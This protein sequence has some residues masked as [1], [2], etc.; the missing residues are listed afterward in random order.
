MNTTTTAQK[1]VFLDSFNSEIE[2]HAPKCQDVKRK[3]AQRKAEEAFEGEYASMKD[4][5]QDYNA[6][7][8]YDPSECWDIVFFPCTKL[9]K[10]KKHYTG[11]AQ[12]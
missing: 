10:E 6:D 9:V 3:V 5:W 1:V 2:A 4:A 11:G 7:F 12:A 8:L